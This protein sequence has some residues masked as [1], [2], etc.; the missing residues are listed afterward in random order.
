LFKNTTLGLLHQAC[1][2]QRCVASEKEGDWTKTFEKH[3]SRASTRKLCV[4]AI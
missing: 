1:G 3:W 2:Q 4:L